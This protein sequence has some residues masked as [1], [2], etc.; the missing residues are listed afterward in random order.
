METKDE[1]W[2]TVVVLELR[3][4]LFLIWRGGGTS[5]FDSVRARTGSV[6]ARCIDGGLR[7]LID[8]GIESAGVMGEDGTG[9]RTAIGGGR[10][11]SLSGARVGTLND[12]R[13][14]VA[15]AGG[16]SNED[17]HTGAEGGGWTATGRL[18]S[19]VSC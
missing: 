5:F 3:K 14:A 10:R 18:A 13:T 2:M 19:G 12:E 15:G 17:F 6:D 4:T 16:T 7:G 1:S 9:G 8:D 11:F